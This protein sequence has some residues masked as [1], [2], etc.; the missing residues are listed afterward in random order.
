[1][2]RPD[3]TFSPGTTVWRN[4]PKLFILALFSCLL[5]AVL[6]G[7]DYNLASLWGLRRQRQDLSR[8]VDSLRVENQLLSDQIKRLENDPG[9]I[10][11]VAREEFGMARRGESIYRVLPEA[12]DSTADTSGAKQE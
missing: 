12:K 8:Q 11:K 7:G 4:R 3:L 1:M 5:L 10:E 9:A 6:I 2:A